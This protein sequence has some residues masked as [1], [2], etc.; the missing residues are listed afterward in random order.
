MARATAPLFGFD[1][2][3]KIGGALVFAKW[4]GRPYVRR[5]VIPKNPKSVKQVSVRSMMKFLSQKWAA[6]AT[7]DQDTWDVR[8]DQNI[9]SA[10]NAYVKVNQ[11]RWKSFLAPGQTDP[12]GATGTPAVL[13]AVTS[14]GGVLLATVSVPVTTAND[15]WGCMIFRST[16]TGFTT[17]F[18]NL[19]AIVLADAVATQVF[20][21]TPLLAGTYFY[22]YREFTD[23]GLL[24]PEDGETSATVTSS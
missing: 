24:G 12:V 3:G 8:A 10:F 17:G 21:D 15:G 6:I 23:D 7:A 11:G 14:V 5:L 16:T 22:N 2:S 1:A 13:G 20:V 4:K 18:D 19:V 9:I